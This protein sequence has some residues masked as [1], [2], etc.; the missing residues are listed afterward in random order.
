MKNLLL[1]L[2]ISLIFSCGNSSIKDIDFSTINEPCDYIDVGEL[3]VDRAYKIQQQYLDSVEFGDHARIL[4]FERDLGEAADSLI[5]SSEIEK[6][7]MMIMDKL[8]ELSKFGNDNWETKDYENCSNFEEVK[9]KTE[10]LKL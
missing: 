2:S 4:L 6:E 7:I 10:E 1:I 3:L 8:N 5:I 9:R